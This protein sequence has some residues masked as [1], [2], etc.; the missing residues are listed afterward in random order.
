[1]YCSLQIVPTEYH[2][3]EKVV[4]KKLNSVI[5]PFTTSFASLR[6]C[7][8]TLLGI[9]NAD[10]HAKPQRRKVDPGRLRLEPKSS[11][12]TTVIQLHLIFKSLN[13]FDMIRR[14]YYLALT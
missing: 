3:E 8:K 6:L 2:K 9:M 11:C 10:F 13:L 4:H 12:P 14:Q 5:K 1:M 7:V